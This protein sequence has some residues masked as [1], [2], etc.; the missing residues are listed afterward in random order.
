VLLLQIHKAAKMAREKKEALR[1]KEL[2]DN[3]GPVR[4]LEREWM[5]ATKILL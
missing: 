5:G 4:R 2:V 3:E 1:L